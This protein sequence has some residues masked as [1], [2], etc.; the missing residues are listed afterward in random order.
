MYHFKS[1]TTC[2][3]AGSFA[4]AG[5]CECRIMYEVNNMKCMHICECKFMSEYKFMSEATN[6]HTGMSDTLC[7]HKCGGWL[8]FG[9]SDMNLHS[10][11]F[12][13]EC[14]GQCRFMY[15]GCMH[16]YE[17]MHACTTMSAYTPMSEVDIA[18]ACTLMNVVYAFTNE[19]GRL[20]FVATAGNRGG[21][22]A[23][24]CTVC[25][26]TPWGGNRQQMPF[27]LCLSLSLS[28]SI[29]ICIYI[30]RYIYIYIYTCVG[31]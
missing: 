31:I 18:H 19:P 27:S 16:T 22:T 11:I 20:V 12:I 30:E 28:L 29:Y 26:R 7:I 8:L 2:V 4:N 3:S 23:C 5:S 25:C 10:E 13:H 9:T 17:C 15:A 14:V 1:V 21:C 6:V 24:C